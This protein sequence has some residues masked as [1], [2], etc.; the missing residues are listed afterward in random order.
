MKRKTVRKTHTLPARIFAVFCCV[1]LILPFAG[2]NLFRQV[3]KEDGAGHGH[4]LGDQKGQDHTHGTEAQ[5]RAVGG[6]DAD[7]RADA[8]NIE[9]IGQDEE[10]Q[11][12]APEDIPG[13]TA[14]VPEDL[15]HG[16]FPGALDIVGLF[17]ILQEGD[18]EDQPP[19]TGDNN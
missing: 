2:C 13:G 18:R 8:V 16:G 14:D 3:R 15:R 4:D 17:H 10:E 19:D 11:A 1:F 12:F 9:E 7:N 5:N 6:G